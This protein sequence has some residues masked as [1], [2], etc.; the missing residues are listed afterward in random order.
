MANDPG[1]IFTD[2]SGC[3]MRTGITVSRFLSAFRISSHSSP[4]RPT[5]ALLRVHV[6]RSVSAG[7]ARRRA[8][9]RGDRGQTG[10]AVMP[11][12]RGPKPKAEA[13]EGQLELSALSR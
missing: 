3:R 1:M 11:R 8:F 2:V 5:S 12:K 4:P 13:P 7:R 6:G 9:R 10:R